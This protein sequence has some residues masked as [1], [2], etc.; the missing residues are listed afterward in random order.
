MGY[1]F[2]LQGI[3]LTQGLNLD[4]CMLQHWQADS[5]PL[6]HQESQWYHVGQSQRLVSRFPRAWNAGVLVSLVRTS[7]WE[8]LG[9]VY[10]LHVF[11]V[12][13]C[14]GEMT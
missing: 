4:L 6:H 3:F 5:L 7:A 13:G 12:C 14:V 1:L 2:L 8:L 11:C 9:L 10:R